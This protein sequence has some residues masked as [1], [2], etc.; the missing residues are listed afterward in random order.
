MKQKIIFLMCLF[1]SL[2]TWAGDPFFV[3]FGTVTLN[4]SVKEVKLPL[5]IS[6]KW[7]SKYHVP[8]IIFIRMDTDNVE[9]ELTPPPTK[10]DTAICTPTVRVLIDN[11]YVGLSSI[12]YGGRIKTSGD[13]VTVKAIKTC[14]KTISYKVRAVSYWNA[15]LRK[16]DMPKDLTC[17]KPN[18]AGW[19]RN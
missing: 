15:A 9:S 5:H 11:G 8:E 1:S 2:L 7:L 6:T 16:E 19:C 17:S 18:T 4:D 13:F 10:N 14:G 12:T 3:E